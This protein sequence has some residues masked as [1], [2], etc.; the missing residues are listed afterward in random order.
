MAEEVSMEE[1]ALIESETAVE[2]EDST[3][4]GMATVTE[5][6]VLGVAWEEEAALETEDG[7]LGFC[8]SV[9]V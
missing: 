3:T 5:L 1:A 8:T 6:G 2:M 9:V 4:G 7:I